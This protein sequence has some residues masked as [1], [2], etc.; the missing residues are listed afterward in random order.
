M[1][2]DD[3]NDQDTMMLRDRFAMAALTGI[4]AS[5]DSED[6]DTVREIAQTAYDF[7]DA[8]LDE[9]AKA[10]PQNAAASP[11]ECPALNVGRLMDNLC[12]AAE[13]LGGAGQRDIASA[14]TE[15]MSTLQKW[16]AAH[17]SKAAPG[18][19]A[20]EERADVVAHLAG[21]TKWVKHLAVAA[22]LAAMGSDFLQGHHVGA[23]AR[24]KAGAT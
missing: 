19:T 18:R 24:A 4:I 23:A 6:V 9:R 15:D 11:R 14:L 8:M 2:K 10:I 21:A 5:T 3:G 17:A 13:R 20:E 12:D 22:M 7:A 16:S 1:R